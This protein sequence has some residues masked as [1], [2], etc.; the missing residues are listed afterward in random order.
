MRGLI[1]KTAHGVDVLEEAKKSVR[2][3][4]H[5]HN[6]LHDNKAKG[7]FKNKDVCPIF[8]PTYTV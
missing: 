1:H 8:H 4:K 7:L 6:N 2:Y 3:G 5:H